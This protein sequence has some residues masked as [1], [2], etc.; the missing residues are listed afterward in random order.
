MALLLITGDQGD[1][2][3]NNYIVHKPLSFLMLLFKF[4]L[5]YS[6]FLSLSFSM[7]GLV[8]FVLMLL[9]MYI[10]L[11]LSLSVSFDMSFFLFLFLFVILKFF[12]N[13]Y[14][15]IISLSVLRYVIHFHPV[16][17]LSVVH[18]ILSFPCFLCIYL[19]FFLSF[20][21]SITRYTS[22]IFLCIFLIPFIFVLAS[23]RNNYTDSE[24]NTIVFHLVPLITRDQQWCACSAYRVFSV[25]RSTNS[26]SSCYAIAICSEPKF[27]KKRK[28]LPLRLHK[29]KRSKNTIH[30]I[31]RNSRKFLPSATR[32]D[33]TKSYVQFTFITV[34]VQFT[35]I[36]VDT[37]DGYF[38]EIDYYNASKLTSSQLIL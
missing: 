34:D 17:S 5:L 12:L 35:F 18:Y 32:R 14:H 20:F 9:F 29:K 37:N 30:K 10:L 11:S 4:I 27:T 23:K 16:I 38:T 19:L 1:K 15:S 6:F 7:V 25:R 33:P 8:F 31:C 13:L 36:T 24:I 28:E 22:F 26:A 21:M 3:K 2:M